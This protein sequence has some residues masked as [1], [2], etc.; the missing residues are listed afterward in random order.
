[1]RTL[2]DLA[3]DQIRAEPERSFDRSD[4]EPRIGFPAGQFTAAGPLLA[5]LTSGLA[6][7]FEITLV[8]LVA[9]LAGQRGAARQTQ[10]R[11]G[12]EGVT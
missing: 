3:K 12:V 5:F 10:G 2:T 8:G 11:L 7:A 4:I 9:A 6:T 1:M